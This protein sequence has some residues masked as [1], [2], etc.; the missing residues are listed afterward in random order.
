MIFDLSVNLFEA[1]IDTFFLY[2][3]SKEHKRKSILFSVLLSFLHFAF[4]TWVNYYSP[5]EL[6]LS[7]VY[8]AAYYMYLSLT[9]DLGR[10]EKLFCAS[11]PTAIYNVTCLVFLFSASWV[12]YGEIGYEPLM[13]EHHYSIIIIVHVIQA[14]LFRVC[15]GKIREGRPLLSETEYAVAA[16]ALI[17]LANLQT[18]F[19]GVVFDRERLSV[20]MLGGIYI[21]MLLI[22]LIVI[23]IHM[24]NSHSRKEAEMEFGMRI[25]H[26]QQMS[27]EKVMQAQQELRRMRHDM[28]HFIDVLC[29]QESSETLQAAAK[30]YQ[31]RLGRS[32]PPVQTRNQAVNYVLNIKRD[33]AVN[34]GIEFVCRLNI[35]HEI[36]MED[37]DLYLML[38]NLLD[39]AI[40]HI[41]MEKKIFVDMYDINQM[42]MI[43]VIN[44]V[45]FNV[46]KDGKIIPE[47]VSAEHGV[48]LHTIRMIAEKYN[49]TFEIDEQDHQFIAAVMLNVPSAKI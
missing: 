20:F 28:K 46:L 24:I 17:L 42:F 37:S 11:I 22:I 16:A 40:T 47:T 19:E 2:S 12:I 10:G 29:S 35:T 9:T 6:F 5:T 21:S 4:I 49:G 30:D 8:I 1:L 13:S 15:A 31:D 18:C 3:L 45:D 32:L 38:S 34:K 43:R 48:G 33:Q 7:L 23:L 14:L 44:S 25:L 27:N 36:G 26:A 39:N 41:G